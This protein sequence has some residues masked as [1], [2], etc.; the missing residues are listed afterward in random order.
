MDINSKSNKLFYLAKGVTLIELIASI[1]IISILASLTIP[2]A[3]HFLNNTEL[4]SSR[5]FYKK[6]VQ[7]AR[8]EAVSNASYG[9]MCHSIH[10][11]LCTDSKDWNRYILVFADLNNNQ[12]LDSTEKLAYKHKIPEKSKV[13]VALSRSKPLIFNETGAVLLNMTLSICMQKSG[14]AIIV[15]RSGRV[16]TIMDKNG[17]SKSDTGT[18][19]M[20][21]HYDN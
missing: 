20:K 10:G 14:A 11:Q 17:D 13:H 16:R 18:D 4:N 9:I 21:C 2:R 5:I 15:S 7:L 8:A 12:Q 19:K 1:T 6:I 3:N